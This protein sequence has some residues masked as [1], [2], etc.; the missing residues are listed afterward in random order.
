MSQILSD[1]E[2]KYTLIEKH[3]FTLVKA[4][5]KFRNFILG[6]Q[7]HVRVPLPTVRFLLTQTHLSGKLAHWLAEIQEHDFTITA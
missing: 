4:I 5:G 3:T 7:T 2:V 6:K 1:D